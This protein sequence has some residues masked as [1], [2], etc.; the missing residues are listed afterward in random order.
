M[1]YRERHTK[2]RVDRRVGVDFDS[3][4]LDEIIN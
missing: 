1:A 4:W 3:L 2:L